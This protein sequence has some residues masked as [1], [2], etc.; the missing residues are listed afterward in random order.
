MSER[1]PVPPKQL[2]DLK[3]LADQFREVYET[4]RT[5]GDPAPA[6]ALK[7]R[8]ETEVA[9]L[10]GESSSISFEEAERLFGKDFFGPTKVEKVFGH[11]PETIPPIP[12]SKTELERAKE[13][14]QQLILQV[15]MLQIKG[16]KAGHVS[17]HPL[18]LQSLKQKFTTSHDGKK[19]FYERD[20]Y[21]SE[22][23]FQNQKPRTGWRL[24]SK[25]LISGSTSKNYVEQT[26]L[27]ATHLIEEVFKGTPVPTPYK[28]AIA[29]WRR[30]KREIEPLAA[31]STEAEWQKGSSMLADLSITKLTRELPIE[32]M[33]RLI[34]N[35]QVN[36]DKPLPSTYTWTAGR[37][38][39]GHLVN[40]G[41][42]DDDGAFV[43]RDGPGLV[44]DYL[45][46]SFSR[47]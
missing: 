32:V 46:V 20:W 33:Y 29:E 18:T 12:F 7:E 4:G 5:T 22:D 35:D 28:E 25:D 17:P 9:R 11:T 41:G 31:S 15:A 30:K 40:V 8:I 47:S 39:D 1:S 26:D 38:S 44:D 6:L 14:G 2:E 3:V 34:L 23:F 42:F 13:L 43:A 21:K 45:G 24:T 16:E 27:L 19:V 36:K 10:R 37:A